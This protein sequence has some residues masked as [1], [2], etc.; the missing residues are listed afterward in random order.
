[1]LPHRRSI[2]TK[3]QANRNYV[4]QY[5]KFGKSIKARSLNKK[6][7]MSAMERYLPGMIQMSWLQD[8]NL[9]GRK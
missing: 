4:S 5:E 9:E 3:S 1:A 2:T 6:Q 7:R 8:V